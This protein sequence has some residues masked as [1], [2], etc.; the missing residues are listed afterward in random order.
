[1]KPNLSLRIPAFSTELS[2]TPAASR[3]NFLDKVPFSDFPVDESIL[4]GFPVRLLPKLRNTPF[5]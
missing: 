4:H 3:L 1:M 2:Q 5:V